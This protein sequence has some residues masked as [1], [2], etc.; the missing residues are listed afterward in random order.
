MSINDTETGENA[1][2]TDVL[3][4][5]ERAMNAHDLDALADCFAQDFRSELPIHPGR[6][7]TGRERMQSN[8][9]GLFAHVPNLA[10]RVLQSV[11]DGDQV[12]SEW[13]IGGTTVEGAQ[14]LSRGVAIL[15]LRGERI[16]SVRFYLDDV[17]TDTS[18]PTP[19]N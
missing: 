19:A 12:W 17:E 18:A 10:A 15:R 8:W 1:E 2:R 3:R 7:F 14:Y 13:E 6:S 16:A 4:R 9:A 11:A 5:M